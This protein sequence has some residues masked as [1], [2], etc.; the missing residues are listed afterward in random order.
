[1][2]AVDKGKRSTAWNLRMESQDEIQKPGPKGKRLVLTKRETKDRT[3][4]S[5]SLED[6]RSSYLISLLETNF[7]IENMSYSKKDEDSTLQLYVPNH[8]MRNMNK[9]TRSSWSNL[10]PSLP[11]T[12][13]VLTLMFLE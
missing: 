13:L 12:S 3:S 8:H 2:A 6:K 9:N 7:C 4:Q 10:F 11:K 1:M 5:P